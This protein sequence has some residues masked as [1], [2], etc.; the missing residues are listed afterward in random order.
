[1]LHLVGDLYDAATDLNKWSDFLR[2]AA[3]CF[4][5]R[6]AQ[7]FIFDKSDRRIGMSIVVGYE[8]TIDD[9]LSR[10]YQELLPTDPR[11]KHWERLPGKPRHERQFMD[12]ETLHASQMYREVLKPAE[13]EYHL[14]FTVEP[15]PGTQCGIALLRDST[16]EPFTDEDC[17]LLSELVPHVR[18][19]IKIQRRLAVL[20]FN[21]R[22]ALES[23]DSIPVGIILSDEFSSV[24]SCNRMAGSFCE[25]KD[26][27]SILNDSV[28]FEDSAINEAVRTAI[29]DGVMQ[30]R[31]GNVLPNQ[32][33]NVPRPSGAAPYSLIVSILWGNHICIDDGLLDEPVAVLYLTDPEHP[34]ETEPELLCRLF[35]LTFAEASLVR[36][37]VNGMTLKEAAL[38]QKIAEGTARQYLKSVFSKMECGSQKDMVARVLTSPAWI[39]RKA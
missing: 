36:R 38:N 23:L 12:E 17:D 34:I 29:F 30:A 39:G 19:A 33:F 31:A 7:V 22:V 9:T 28:L 20:D 3:R 11:V 1:V 21:N 37:L 15:E 18:R 24:R 10:R 26:G 35:G 13:M 14:T 6:G 32:A 5:S 27:V 16:E 2:A 25:S 4:N 8:G